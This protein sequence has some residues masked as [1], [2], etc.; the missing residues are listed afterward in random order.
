MCPA[1]TALPL[2]VQIIFPITLL[3]TTQQTNLLKKLGI[4]VTTAVTIIWL[5]LMPKLQLC[6][7]HT[8]V[9]LDTSAS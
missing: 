2:I 5:D 9:E 1:T 6:S 3:C 8:S 4:C 7:A